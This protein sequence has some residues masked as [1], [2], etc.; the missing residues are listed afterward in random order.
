MT[1]GKRVDPGQPAARFA[2]KMITAKALATVM[3]AVDQD[4]QLIH[5]NVPAAAF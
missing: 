4:L 2:A 5:R 3:G 1:V